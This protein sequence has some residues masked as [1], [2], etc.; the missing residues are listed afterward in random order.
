MKDVMAGQE[1]PLAKGELARFQAVFDPVFDRKWNEVVAPNRDI[2][3]VWQPRWDAVW[4]PVW[5][6]MFPL[7]GNKPYWS[8]A[9]HDGMKAQMVKTM[10]DVMAGQERPLAKGE[11]ARFQAVFDPV[12]DR[13]WNE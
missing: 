11:L 9:H 3:E 6:A 4:Q 12:F 10:K 8:T 7:S 2:P 5:D 1:R 13:K